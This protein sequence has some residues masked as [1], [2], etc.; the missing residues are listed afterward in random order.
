MIAKHGVV[1]PQIAVIT[2]QNIIKSNQLFSLPVIVP[3]HYPDERFKS[4][5]S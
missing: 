4:L 5:V 2:W 3:I 1:V